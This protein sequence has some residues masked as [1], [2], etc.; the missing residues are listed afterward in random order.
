MSKAKKQPTGDYDIGYAKPP[1]ETRFQTGRS[2]NPSGRPKG[3][4][5]TRTILKD[6]LR[7]K[8]GVNLNGRT[9]RRTMEEAIFLA[10]GGEALKNFRAA[11]ALMK[12]SARVVGVVDEEPPTSFSTEP[13]AL[14]ELID[15]A[16]KLLKRA[17]GKRRCDFPPPPPA[18]VAECYAHSQGELDLSR[19]AEPPADECGPEGG[20]ADSQGPQTREG[21]ESL[22]PGGAQAPPKSG[23]PGRHVEDPQWVPDTRLDEEPPD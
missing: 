21:A 6:T 9:S 10:W 8:V 3:R 20:D 19:S 4:K 2:G 23:A 5:G 12:F 7:E 11:D 22:P 16:N 15:T 14:V 17:T 18:G 1:E 13:E